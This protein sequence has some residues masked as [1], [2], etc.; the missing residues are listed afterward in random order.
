MINRKRP[1]VQ[2]GRGYLNRNAG[3]I[4]GGSYPVFGCTANVSTKAYRALSIGC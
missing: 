1:D 3:N 2:I 4:G